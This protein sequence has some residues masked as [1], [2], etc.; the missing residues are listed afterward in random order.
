VAAIL[1]ECTR[2][3]DAGKRRVLAGTKAIVVG[4]TSRPVPS[5]RLEIADDDWLDVPVGDLA[6]FWKTHTPAG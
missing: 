4:A 5:V 6:K 3:Y 1:A 2:S